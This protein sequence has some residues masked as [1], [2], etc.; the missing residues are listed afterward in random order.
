MELRSVHLSAECGIR[1]KSSSHNLTARVPL[2]EESYIF[3]SQ[4]LKYKIPMRR[5]VWTETNHQWSQFINVSRGTIPLVCPEL[6]DIYS[7]PVIFLQQ[8]FK[9]LVVH[10]LFI[11]DLQKIKI[12][13]FISCLFCCLCC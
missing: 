5:I 8:A 12:Y 10:V 2:F 4:I 9:L 11:V 7:L 3:A 13:P 1:Q 6:H